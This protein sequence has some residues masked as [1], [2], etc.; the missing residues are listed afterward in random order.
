[1]RG[2]AR[3]GEPLHTEGASPVGP[4]TF[5][6]ATIVVAFAL[7]VWGRVRYELVGL[8]AMVVLALGGALPTSEIFRGFANDAVLSVI[9][10]M[11]VGRALRIAGATEPFAALLLRARGGPRRPSRSR[12]PCRSSLRS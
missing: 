6:M 7:F 4:Q 2:G 10:V 5:V 3:S 1:M 8:S 11:I 9:A 12:G